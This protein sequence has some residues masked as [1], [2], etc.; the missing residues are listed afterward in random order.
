MYYRNNIDSTLTLCEVMNEHNVKNIVFSSSATVYGTPKS[1][2]IKENF[3]V[4]HATNPYGETK[5]IRYF[6][7]IGA[8]KSGLIGENPNDIPNNLMP[9]IVKV[10]NKELKELSVFGN[11]YD[12]ID[13]TG[14]RDYIHVVDLAKGHIKALNWVLNNNG[15]DAFNLGT[16][17]GYSVLELVEA[18]KKFNNI[19]VPYKI[20]GRR[21]GDI[22][23]CYADAS[24]A[25]DILDWSCTYNIEDMVKD[26][27]N[28]V[29]N[30]K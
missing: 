13:G 17:N 1:L 12:T 3:D 9:Y 2:P 19:D 10:A 11:D 28:Y 29:K 16:G 25:K 14:V 18:F 23:S 21:D 5:I 20:V 6:N 8:H 26:S 24:K 7:P 22:A 27:Y 30:S 15:I 4:T